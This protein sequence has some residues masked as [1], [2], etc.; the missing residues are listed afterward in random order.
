MPA[1]HANAIGVQ[2]LQFA[3]LFGN[4]WK[5]CYWDTNMG[6]SEVAN[7]ILLNNPLPRLWPF[8]RGRGFMTRVVEQLEFGWWRGDRLLPSRKPQLLRM[9]EGTDF[10]YAAPLRNSEATRCREILEVIQCPF[11]VHLWDV[12]DNP[13]NEDYEW[14]FSRAERVFCLSEPMTGLIK[15]AARQKTELL[16]FARLRPKC[17][18]FYRS[19][20]AIVIGLVGFLAA[21]RE[22]LN[23]LARVIE[24]LKARRVQVSLRYVGHPSQFQYLPQRL[25]SITECVGMPDDDERDRLL[26]ECNVAFLPGPFLAPQDDQRSRYSVPSRVADYLAVGLPVIAAVHPKSATSL[27]LST[28]RGRGFFP[29]S[30]EDGLASA[31]ETLGDENVWTDASAECVSFFSDRCE[32]GIVLEKFHAVARRF[33]AKKGSGQSFQVDLKSD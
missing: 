10:A 12:M 25:K 33:L 14:L 17:R 29:A 31:M 11:V 3:S 26:A 28:L 18:A 15:D 16:G 30:D 19:G 5:H 6:E 32:S 23:L 20:D 9:L 4:A 24:I 13:L 21:Y 27:F 8:A 2:T 7:S 1:S 22:G